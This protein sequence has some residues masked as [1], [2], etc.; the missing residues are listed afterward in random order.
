MSPQDTRMPSY[1][2][3][4]WIWKADVPLLYLPPYPRPVSK[5]PFY[6]KKS[7]TAKHEL[8]IQSSLPQTNY[9]S[10][11]LEY[12]LT[13]NV[14]WFVSCTWVIHT[15][16]AVP[17]NKLSLWSSQGVGLPTHRS[18]LQCRT[19]RKKSLLRTSQIRGVNIQ[20]NCDFI[21]S[22]YGY[23]VSPPS[24]LSCDWSISSSYA[25]FPESGS[26]PTS[27]ISSLP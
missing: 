8:Q 21:V 7:L 1:Y 16:A 5:C 4:S 15:V 12:L 9:F 3:G 11:V 20:Q 17:E 27:S 19:L 2:T 13:Y 24:C 25:T 10:T 6:T 14:G 22:F 26:F 18:T 23:N